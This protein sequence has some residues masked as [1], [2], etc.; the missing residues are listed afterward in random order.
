[1]IEEFRVG[2]VG[3]GYVGLA[4][5]ACLAHV[6]HRVVCVDKNEDRVSD[7]E[8]GRMPIYEPNLEEMVS[9]GVGRERLFFSTQLP[10][11]VHASDTVFIAADTPQGEDGSADL[12]SIAAVARSIGRALAEPSHREPR[13]HPLVVVNKSTV[14]VGNKM[15]SARCSFRRA[16]RNRG[17]GHV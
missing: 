9:R 14:P 8:K 2:V 11:V 13:S 15:S 6:G 5:G 16:P 4:T 3:A 7:L 10:E 1:M 17:F 12:S